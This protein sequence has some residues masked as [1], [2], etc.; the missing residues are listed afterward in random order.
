MLDFRAVSLAIGNRWLLSQANS[1]ERVRAVKLRQSAKPSASQRGPQ[2][3]D[4]LEEWAIQ[5]LARRT[6]PDQLTLRLNSGQDTDRYTAS[7]LC[8]ILSDRCTLPCDLNPSLPALVSFPGARE[9][10]QTQARQ[11]EWY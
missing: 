7:V 1:A 11:A 10:G 8:P 9:S 3:H 2:R 6:C 5:E 4:H